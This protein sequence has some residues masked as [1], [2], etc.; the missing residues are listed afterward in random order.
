M[1]TKPPSVPSTSTANAVAQASG[2]GNGS[3]VELRKQYIDVARSAT[4]EIG[5]FAM[6]L[7]NNVK[8]PTARYAKLKGNIEELYNLIRTMEKEL[9]ST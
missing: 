7:T 9:G 3:D 4:H 1:T 6:F 5:M 2:G 8:Y